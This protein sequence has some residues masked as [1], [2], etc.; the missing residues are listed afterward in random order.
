MLQNTSDDKSTLAQVLQQA[1]T[2]DNV[3]QH[4]CLHNSLC[5]VSVLNGFYFS[6]LI[7]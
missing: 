3:N 2:I 1:I 5:N 6:V 4:L 7:T